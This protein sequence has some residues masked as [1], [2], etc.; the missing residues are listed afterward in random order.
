MPSLVTTLQFLKLVVFDVDG[1]LTDGG[2]LYDGLGESIKKFNVKDGV[3]IK[4][5][6]KWG[7]QVAFITAK[8]S[9]PLQHRM[10]DLEAAHFYSVCHDKTTAFDDIIATLQ[11]EPE[12]AAYV[13]DD[14]IDLP[15]MLKVGV[16]LC[17]S[18]AHVLLQRYCHLVL[19]KRGGQGVAR[20]MAD[21]V[22]A[23]RM[24][25]ENAYEVTQTP[26]FEKK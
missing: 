26:E 14:V 19:N 1:V 9:A 15:V 23:S 3:A 24:L 8:A 11:L 16:A 5:L 13:G 17:P 20:E 18:D 2:L 10:S 6:P 21:L 22:L 25:L 12:Q 7:V 4:L